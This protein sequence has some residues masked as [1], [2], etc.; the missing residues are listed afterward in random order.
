MLAIHKKDE[1]SKPLTQISSTLVCPIC[2][3]L[4]D[5]PYQVKCCDEVYCKKC[6][7]DEILRSF[8]CPNCKIESSQESIFPNKAVKSFCLFYQKCLSNASFVA[9]LVRKGED[10]ME[11]RETYERRSN[12][13]SS[14][15]DKS[16]RKHRKSVDRTV[17]KEKKRINRKKN[18]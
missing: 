5:D 2:S 15:D 11:V 1:S 3:G 8:V 6:V 17:S 7:L 18:R 16:E 10:E 9:E 4:F 12:H 14:R 13:S